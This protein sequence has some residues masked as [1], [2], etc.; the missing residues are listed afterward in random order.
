MLRNCKSGTT[1]V[2][3]LSYCTPTHLWVLAQA[4]HL[5]KVCHGLLSQNL[6]VANVAPYNLAEWVAAFACLQVLLNH[7]GP[8]DNLAAHCIL[9]LDHPLVNCGGRQGGR[10]PTGC[11]RH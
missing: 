7:A 10:N 11:R 3:M 5:P 8:P 2:C 9:C 6:G 1:S 4:Q